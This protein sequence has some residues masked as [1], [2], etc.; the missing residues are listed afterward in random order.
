MA[1]TPS[2]EG[3]VAA[4]PEILYF[5]ALSLVTK[6][7]SLKKQKSGKLKASTN[8]QTLDLHFNSK[9]CNTGRHAH[10]TVTWRSRR[11]RAHP[12]LSLLGRASQHT[13]A[14]S[15]AQQEQDASQRAC[16]G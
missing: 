3:Q 14:S 10:H 11:E 2:A 5:A 4:A 16:A 9:I 1:G 13:S 15:D 12:C 7:E 6:Q 8:T